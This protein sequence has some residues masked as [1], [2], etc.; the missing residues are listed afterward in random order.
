[1]EPKRASSKQHWQPPL[2]PGSRGR[3]YRF[4]LLA[5]GALSPWGPLGL[6]YLGSPNT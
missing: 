6:L 1:M 4:L 5:E 3:P 2:G